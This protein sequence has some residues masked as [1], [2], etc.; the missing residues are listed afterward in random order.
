MNSRIVRK[1]QRH[2]L[3]I[4]CTCTYLVIDHEYVGLTEETE[5]EIVEVTKLFGQSEEQ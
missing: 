2:A 4:T 5:G 1:G 3:D